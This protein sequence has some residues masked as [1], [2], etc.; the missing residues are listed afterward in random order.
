MQMV[1]EDPENRHQDWWSV[2]NG[3]QI[4]IIASFAGN[5]RGVATRRFDTKETVI[6]LNN[7]KIEAFHH[8][9]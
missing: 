8:I 4:S 5:S 9:I 2:I 7:V 3:T 6:D 1:T